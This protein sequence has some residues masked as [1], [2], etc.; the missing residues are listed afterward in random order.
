VK[1]HDRITVRKH[2]RIQ[3]VYRA[4]MSDPGDLQIQA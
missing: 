3:R 2:L 4:Y 1:V